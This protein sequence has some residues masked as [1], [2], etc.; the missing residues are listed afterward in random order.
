[1]QLSGTIIRA[2]LS[3]I[4]GFIFFRQ[5]TYLP[6]YAFPAF[7]GVINCNNALAAGISQDSS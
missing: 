4:N 6:Y 1:M 3:T 5:Q 2:S 7:P